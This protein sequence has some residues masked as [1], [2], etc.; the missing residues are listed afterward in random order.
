M[1][2]PQIYYLKRIPVRDTFLVVQSTSNTNINSQITYIYIYIS[3]VG[4]V[5]VLKLGKG[6]IVLWVD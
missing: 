5:R 6:L 3:Q 2:N 1:F 4:W